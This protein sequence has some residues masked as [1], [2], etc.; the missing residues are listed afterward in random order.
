M[1]YEI[2][3]RELTPFSEE[4]MKEIDK[5]NSFGSYD[6]PRCSDR[7]FHETRVMYS[8]VTPEEFKAIKKAVIDIF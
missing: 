6:N 2:T 1:K 8:Q 4:E 7:P 3:I 5:R